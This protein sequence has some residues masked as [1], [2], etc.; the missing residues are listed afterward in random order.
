[1]TFFMHDI[2]WDCTRHRLTY[3]FHCSVS[4]Q[5]VIFT[6]LHCIYLVR[7]E[8]QRKSLYQ[9]SKKS[10]LDDLGSVLGRLPYS[11]S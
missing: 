7:K 4:L 10:S 11:G 8:L 1:M 9:K 2:M 3:S 6:G 5:K